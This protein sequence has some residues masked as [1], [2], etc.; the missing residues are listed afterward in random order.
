MAVFGIIALVAVLVGIASPIP[1]WVSRALR[2]P[3]PRKALPA[4]KAKP[5]GGEAGAVLLT[6]INTAIDL[7]GRAWNAIAD[8]RATVHVQWLFGGGDSWVHNVVRHS[9]YSEEEAVQAVERVISAA[10]DLPPPERTR[11]EDAYQ[12][13]SALIRERAAAEHDESPGR[14]PS[15]ADVARTLGLFER[16]LAQLQV[17]RD[18]LLSLQAPDA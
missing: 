4:G 7:V 11:L 8:Y 10:A 13:L 6:E 9:H 12:P 3:P 1:V 18:R 14:R 5:A 17:L 15:R 16:T 2:A